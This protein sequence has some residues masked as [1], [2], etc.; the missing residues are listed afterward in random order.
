MK[1]FKIGVFDGKELW[2]S[3]SLAVTLFSFVKGKEGN[4]FILANQRGKGTPY[5]QG[6][7][8]CSCGYLDFDETAKEAAVRETF[9]ETGVKVD[10]KLIK[11]IGFN[12]NPKDD[13][14]Q[15][16]TFRYAVILPKDISF[17]KKEF[18]KKNNEEDEVSN[19]KF[20][21]LKDLDKY[22]W[23]FNHKTLI[24]KAWSKIYEKG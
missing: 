10:K 3:R 4:V 14:L 5:N 20:I 19:I 7:W 21:S 15:N 24:K 22:N 12:S 6:Q 13:E 18:S 16:V 9:E 2:Y 23:A 8:N 11:F 17:Y 1:N